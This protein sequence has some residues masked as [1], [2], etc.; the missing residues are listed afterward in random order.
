PVFLKTV[1][2]LGF[3]FIAEVEDAGSVEIETTTVREVEIREELAPLRALPAPNLRRWWTYVIGGLIL[4]GLVAFALLD[5]TRNG[6][7]DPILQQ[8]PGKTPLAVMFFENRSSNH[9]LDWLREGLADMLITNLSRSPKLAVLPREHLRILLDRAGHAA[10]G[11]IG[12]QEALDVARKGHA[13]VVLLGAFTSLGDS[14][15]L[16]VQIYDTAAGRMSAAE[17]LTVGRAPE[18]LA[19]FDALSLRLALRLNAPIPGSAA[20]AALAEVRTNNIEA[21]RAYSTGVER[22][23][24]FRIAE[25]VELF[26][27]AAAL[28]PGFVMPL[29]RIGHAYAVIGGMLE[30]GKPY[31]E[32]AFRRSNALTSRER[33][34]V[35]A[36]YSIAKRDYDGA[37][38]AY[39]QIATEYPAEVP[40]YVSLGRAL[41]GEK[42]AA[43]A[44]E[45]LERALVLDPEA[46][47]IHNNLAI[48]YFEMGDAH[49]AV[50][51]A[52]RYTELA[53][54]EPNAFDSL[55]LIYHRAGRYQ[56]AIETYQHALQL[57][58]DFGIA[59][60]HLGN[61]FVQLGRYREAIGQYRRF[62]ETGALPGDRGRGLDAI[63]WVYWKKGDLRQADKE[64]STG[65][66]DVS[67]R[68]QAVIGFDRG[69]V[70]FSEGLLKVLSE[71]SHQGNPSA[72]MTERWQH[73]Y[74]GHV[75]WKSGRTAEAVRSFESAIRELPPYWSSSELEDCLA[76]GYLEL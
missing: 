34:Y 28:D 47:D 67:R 50:A 27:K 58:P 48:V 66:G 29:A 33:L 73:F 57:K 40:A 1:P 65:P 38:R 19:R 74:Q 45:V 62:I 35:T 20:L 69:R 39:R 54:L 5:R 32:Q 64:L 49:Q 10:S 4:A 22:A 21:F 68:I 15:R 14:L 8:M 52:R 23:E 44:R 36:W 12:L 41:R 7:L 76:D 2:K 56:E 46:G 17:S 18:L 51:S 26:R 53:P 63:A 59:Q 75:E 25:A 3:R 9:D 70:P 16:D 55:A 11:T 24:Q 6:R 72:R 71:P 37:I 61:T 31:L 42:R 43:E 60:L 30:E 13:R